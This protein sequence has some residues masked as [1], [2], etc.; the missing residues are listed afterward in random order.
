MI[1]SR[2]LFCSQG[3]LLIYNTKFIIVLK[4]PLKR[5]SRV[6]RSVSIDDW[7]LMKRSCFSAQG[8]R[9]NLCRDEKGVQDL[10]FQLGIDLTLVFD[11]QMKCDGFQLMPDVSNLVGTPIVCHIQ[12]CLP[13]LSLYV[14]AWFKKRGSLTG[15][16]FGI[17]PLVASVVIAGLPHCPMHPAFLKSSPVC[18][19]APFH[20]YFVLSRKLT[21]TSICNFS[22]R[23][24]TINKTK[25]ATRPQTPKSH[26]HS[27]ARATAAIWGTFRF[28]RGWCLVSL[29]S[30]CEGDL[31]L[32]LRWG[33][34]GQENR[35]GGV[36][37]DFYY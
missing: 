6:H 28:V 7:A 11:P 10:L 12:N 32:L 24:K 21:A 2:L 30:V 33:H 29:G 8:K 14:S 20:N 35:K 16:D 25:A 18:Q 13:A 26:C 15:S 37:I 27:A 36:L 31:P 9:I 23:K 3:A 34:T 5:S 17:L 1:V 19:T 4:F 22:T